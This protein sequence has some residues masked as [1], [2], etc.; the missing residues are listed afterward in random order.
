MIKRNMKA[1]T[2]ILKNVRLE[3]G[4][5]FDGEEVI[6]TNTALCCV[7]VEA[8]KI[9][10]IKPNTPNA[11]GIDAK[12]HLMLPAFKDMHAHLDK[13]LFGLPWEAV[14]PTRHT[15]KDMIA[16]EQKMIPE[17]LSTSV[18][19]TGKML[20]F[21]QAYGTDFIRSHFNVDPTSGLRSLTNLE[22][23]L[24][25]KKDTVDVELVAFPQHG[26]YYTDTLP[27]LKDVAKL[28]AVSFIGGVD[29]YSLD[30]S[31]EKSMEQITR[32]AL[33]NDKGVDIHLHEMGE[34]GL[35]TIDFL[36]DRTLENPQL[37]GKAFVS[38][39]FA[40][41]RL[42]N[43][44]VEKIAARLAEAGVGI[45]SSVPFGNMIMP[46]PTLRKYGVEVL[47]GNDNIQDHWNTFGSGNM[48]QKANLIAEL[49]GYGTE[50]GLSRT[51]AFATRYKLPL[52]NNGNQ[53][54]PKVGDEASMVFVEA[55]CSAEAVSR[56]SPV[57]S[58][59]HKGNIV[60]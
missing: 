11:N 8:G 5:E 35:K 19:R 57:T 6:S 7:E 56:I 30:G 59:I 42:A 54:W 15:V 60:F 41:S 24:A 49:Y 26:L 34:S 39:A 4:F 50:F 33:D 53:Q 12:G 1:K 2:Y 36:I 22:K 55:S 10:G 20:N 46:I 47:I 14:S 9:K 38:H 51:L 31:I 23:A 48:L 28:D 58:L 18:E 27:I 29:P 3:T 16:Y 32:L 17:W 43:V 13:M 37:K 40:L 44:E 45:V 21:L 52:D 25:S